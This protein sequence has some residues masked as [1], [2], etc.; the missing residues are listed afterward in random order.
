MSAFSNYNEKLVSQFKTIIQAFFY[1]Y[2][3]VLVF[4][5]LGLAIISL[6]ITISITIIFA[7]GIYINSKSDKLKDGTFIAVLFALTVILENLAFFLPSSVVGINPETS[8]EFLE[9]LT[10]LAN[11]LPLIILLLIII[12]ITGGISAIW[13]NKWYSNYIPKE[14][15][16]TNAFLIY[17]LILIIANI[18][19]IYSFIEVIIRFG[20]GNGSSSDLDYIGTISLVVQILNLIVGI[21]KIVA[22]YIIYNR[23]NLFYRNFISK[24]SVNA[25]L[26]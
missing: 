14:F 17:G 20:S 21:I 13:F 8:Q 10:L 1:G 3:L 15:P 12:T 23:I 19:T 26:T 24:E 16:K 25:L 9:Y 11:D 5:F 6:L 2:L 22:I 7:Y 4:N 18:I